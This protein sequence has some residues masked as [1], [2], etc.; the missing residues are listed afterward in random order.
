MN[1]MRQNKQMVCR[2]LGPISRFYGVGL[3]LRS[4]IEQFLLAIGTELALLLLEQQ[5]L[6]SLD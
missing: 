2:P 6:L 1:G 5:S 4:F 3:D